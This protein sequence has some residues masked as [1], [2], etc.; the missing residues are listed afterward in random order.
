MTDKMKRGLSG[1]MAVV[2]LDFTGRGSASKKNSYGIFPLLLSREELRI[3]R[4]GVENCLPAF[5]A[6]EYR[7]HGTVLVHK[8]YKLAKKAGL[9]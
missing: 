3:L 9:K 8:V 4:H 7:K 2:F 6:P 5:C 1:W